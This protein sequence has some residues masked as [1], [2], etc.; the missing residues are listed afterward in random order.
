MKL[1]TLL[2]L[3]LTALTVNTATYTTADA[4]SNGARNKD[5]SIVTG[6]LTA[7]FDPNAGLDGVPIP[8]NLFYLGT[9]DLTLNAPTDG[10]DGT[11]AA[12]VE[13]INALDG[14]STTE[15]WTTTFVD[16]DRNPGAIDPDS[17]VPG[18]SVR[19]FQVTTQ[20][21]VAVTGIIR[22]LT[23]GVDYTAAASG[24]V[25]AIVPLQ[26]LDEYSSYMAVLTN[27]INDAAG[28]DA[29]PDQTYFLTKRAEPWVDENG[30]STYPLIDD[31]TAQAL[32]QLQPL[33]ASMEAAAASAGINPE[34]IILS[35]TV[36][37]QS[38]TPVLGL[39]RSTVQP[40]DVQL[41]GPL[42]NTSD[43]G[44]PGTADYY[45][46]AIE[47]PYYLGVPSAENPVAP[48]TDFWTAEPGAYLPPFD[49]LGLDPTSTNIT[50]AN[51][52][53]VV[54]SVET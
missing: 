33:T 51:P 27:D 4:A 38:I 37:T 31:A 28:N 50:L 20:Q 23:P 47:V 25:L 8:N 15:R 6:V 53:P 52:F 17:V 39:L 5:G 43:F 9:T 21:F 14:F 12:L 44:L 49:Q 42:G 7:V 13:Q 54:T 36:Q 22:E 1:R 40:A 32:A 46:G 35:W 3:L 26:P 19:V 45:I 48:L 34:D 30:Q 29:T 11:A 24:N 10:L 16:D 18:Q 2:P 41:V